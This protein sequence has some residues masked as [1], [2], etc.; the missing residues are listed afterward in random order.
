MTNE[1]MRIFSL[2]IFIFILSL[3][4]AQLYGQS[5]TLVFNSGNRIVGEIKKMEKGILEI[6]AAYGDEN[7]KIKWLQI[8]YIHTTSKF[9]INIKNQIYEGQ[10]AT[11]SD[12]T[13]RVF[14]ADSTYITCALEDIVYLKQYK[15][16]FSNRFSAAVEVGFN[17]TKAQDVRQFSFRSSVGYKTSKSTFS[18]SYNIL[19][20]SQSNTET[21]KRTDG[22]LNYSR[23]LIKDWYGLASIYTLSNTEQKIDLRANSQLGIGN[24]LYATNRAYWGIVTGVNNNLERFTNSESNRNTWEVFYGTELNLYDIED[25]NLAFVFVGYSGLTEKGRFRADTT[26][27]AKYDLPWDLFIRLGFSLNYDNQPAINASQTDYILRT[28][29]GWEW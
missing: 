15:D 18:A 20:A 16:G 25:F 22:L 14:Q 9:L 1:G 4:G 29:I 26:I 2:S 28:G 23:I 24:Y 27:D 5:D 10:I 7:F 8:D 13:I 17:L 11:E 19:R 12:K 21:V 3:S 6:D